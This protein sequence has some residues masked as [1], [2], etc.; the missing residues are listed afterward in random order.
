MRDLCPF[1]FKLHNFVIGHSNI[2]VF[3]RNISSVVISRYLMFLMILLI[4]LMCDVTPVGLTFKFG[5]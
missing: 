1:K 2:G 4:V 5:R 3:P